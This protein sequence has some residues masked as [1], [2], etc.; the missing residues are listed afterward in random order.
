MNI[1]AQWFVSLIWWQQIVL[2]FFIG[3]CISQIGN[4]TVNINKD[5]K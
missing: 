5:N 3:V 4:T 2:I 1:L